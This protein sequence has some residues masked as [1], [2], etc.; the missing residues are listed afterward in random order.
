[1]KRLLSVLLSVILALS[2]LA[3]A[4]AY[5]A[6][7]SADLSAEAGAMADV[8][9]PTSFDL[10]AADLDGSGVL[11]NYVTP[12][13]RQEPFGSCWGFSAIAAAETSILTEL[14][15]SYD[16]WK[17]TLGW[18][19]DLSEHHLMWFANTPLPEDNVNNQTGE[20]I[21]VPDDDKNPNMRMNGGGVSVMATSVFSSGIGPVREDY[22]PYMGANGDIMYLTPE[23]QFSYDDGGGVNVPTCYSDLDDW[24]IDESHRFGQF[25]PLEESF[26]LP[27][28]ARF[29]PANDGSGNSVYEYNPV[30]TNAAKEQLLQGRPVQVGYC[31][32]PIY[33]NTDTWGHYTP[34]NK[35]EDPI[36]GAAFDHAVTIVGW[37]DNFPKEF[38]NQGN[39]I[40]PA[41]GAWIVKNS[42]GSESNEFPNKYNWGD[43]G[44]FYLSYYDHTLSVM[45]ALDFDTIGSAS[46]VYYNFKYNYLPA[47]TYGNYL[48]FDEPSYMANNFTAKFGDMI[49][50]TLTLQTK[51][52][53][54]TTTFE[55][56]E[57]DDS[58]SSPTSGKL[59]ARAT[60]TFPYGGYHRVNLEKPLFI[61]KGTRFSVV[62]TNMT[63]DGRYEI[64]CDYNYSQ[65][66]SRVQTALVEEPTYPYTYANS[67]INKGESLIGNTL[68]D[69][70]VAWNDWKDIVSDSENMGVEFLN[71]IDFMGTLTA[72]ESARDAF[73][74][75]KREYS[76]THPRTDFS[77]LPED[78][79]PLYND[80]QNLAANL[81]VTFNAIQNRDYNYFDLSEDE[82]GQIS[83]M[84]FYVRDNFPIGVIGI[85]VEIKDY[86]LYY[87]GAT[88]RLYSEYDFETHKYSNPV[89]I[90]GATGEGSTLTLNSDFQFATTCADGLFLGEGTTLNVPRGER[91]S[92]YSGISEVTVPGI[93][94]ENSF[95][96]VALG[97]YPDCTLNIDGILEVT[98]GDSTNAINIAVFGFGK[99]NITGLGSLVARSG[100]SRFDETSPGTAANSVGI[101]SYG[102]LNIS[103]AVVRVSAG[104]SSANSLCMVTDLPNSITV[105]GGSNI[106][107]QSGSS[108]GRDTDASFGCAVM[109]LTVRDHSNLNIIAADS[110]GGLCGG[111]QVYCDESNSG[112]ITLLNNSTL[113][114]TGVS[115]NN[116]YGIVPFK[117]VPV[118]VQ[119]DGDCAF[120]VEG[121]TMASYSAELRGVS[122][123]SEGVIVTYD[124]E[125]NS[126]V[127]ADGRP[128][129][130]LTIFPEY[131]IS[132][133]NGAAY[134]TAPA[135]S[136][137]VIFAAY[138]ENERLVGTQSIELEFDRWVT[139]VVTPGGFGA[140]VK[141]VKI[142]LWNSLNEMMAL[143]DAVVLNG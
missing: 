73:K 131:D 105:S 39:G 114:V 41:N 43:D 67:V 85:P 33:L 69:D 2:V 30:G 121:Q 78:L 44:Y 40:P 53:D 27:D 92:I 93:T 116:S 86:M 104:D 26:L 19:M 62:V 46:G 123:L 90:P 17:D 94:P 102:D 23:G 72:T 96:A 9:F 110:G 32:N 51:S 98:S 55:V 81:A 18:D 80:W 122:V 107:V 24:S 4:P 29:V 47:T 45:E 54:T 34:L 7:A 58:S 113:T 141:K 109:N 117:I 16:E 132:Y 71:S 95:G 13:K 3:L 120:T 124:S 21:I 103:L 15:M 89:E 25:F 133:I 100:V 50:S 70:L 82:V 142:M 8:S 138:D 1:M 136:C 83:D 36:N 49:L 5:A 91:P 125:R 12:V 135:G 56:Y 129:K 118:I 52:Q 65:L 77:V 115:P 75:A 88:S 106:T 108:G 60:K 57:L 101:Y 119:M 139:Q 42:W 38:F 134:V 10:R 68:F 59:L 97:A 61:R 48:V 66:T 126:Y 22:Y 31:S 11:K 84:A 14:K 99:L 37:D 137:T 28:P 130:K 128:V 111:L 64:V 143:C 63:A 127:D 87:D 79:V 6:A 74:N 76:E 140:E 20:G 35:K 112:R